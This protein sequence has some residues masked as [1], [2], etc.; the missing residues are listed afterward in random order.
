VNVAGA[1]LVVL[2]LV[3]IYM[4]RNII[5]IIKMIDSIS[6]F[7]DEKTAILMRLIKDLTIMVG[8]AARINLDSIPS[9]LILDRLEVS[10]QAHKDACSSFKETL[11]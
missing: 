4:N 8:D 5:E 1:T 7:D 11:L 3:R 2:E 10:L 6:K 9:Q